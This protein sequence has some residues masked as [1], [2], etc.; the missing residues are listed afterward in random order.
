MWGNWDA[1]V[2]LVGLQNGATALEN[3]K[4]VPWKIENRAT[5]WSTNSSSGSMSKKNWK[6]DLK[7]ISV[8]AQRVVFTIVKRSKQ[9]K[10]PSVNEWIK[11]TC[12]VHIMEYYSASKRKEILTHARTWMN[13]EDAVLSKISQSQKDKYC[14]ISLLQGIWRVKLMGTESTMVLTRVCGRG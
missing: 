8:H 11:K 7:E 1:C 2:L 4:E 12:N 13:F 6:R 9:P 5:I 3:S 14:N 10:C